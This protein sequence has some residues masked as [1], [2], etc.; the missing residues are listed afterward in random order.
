VATSLRASRSRYRRGIA[1]LLGF[2]VLSAVAAVGLKLAEYRFLVLEHSVET[3]VTLVATLFAGVGI[4]LGWTLTRRQPATA[5]A[6]ASAPPPPQSFVADA[7]RLAELGI[8]PRE[9]ETLSLIAAG[10]SNREIAGR[11]GVSEST[12]KTHCSRV[13]SKLGA[14]RRTQAVHAGR[15]AGLIP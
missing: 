8:T 6:E 14:R 11:L 7:A 5:R 10:L 12:V 1:G 13:L 9:L 2:G 4:W 3:Y 15:A